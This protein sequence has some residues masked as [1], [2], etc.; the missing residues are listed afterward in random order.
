[1]HTKYSINIKAYALY[2]MDVEE[3]RKEYDDIK[4]QLVEFLTSTSLHVVADTI[5]S[6]N[7]YAYIF[8]CFR[9][10]PYNKQNAPGRA[11]ADVRHAVEEQVI[12]EVLKDMVI[13][14]GGILR[15]HVKT[16]HGP[17][18]ETPIRQGNLL[19]C[20]VNHNTKYEFKIINMVDA[21]AGLDLTVQ[22]GHKTDRKPDIVNRKMEIA[23]DDAQEV[24]DVRLDPED[25][26][27]YTFTKDGGAVL[28]VL[29]T[30]PDV[31]FPFPLWCDIPHAITEDRPRDAP[32]PDVDAKLNNIQ[33]QFEKENGNGSSSFFEVLFDDTM[34]CR[35]MLRSFLEYENV[36]VHSGAGN[37]FEVSG[38]PVAVTALYVVSPETVRVVLDTQ[39]ALEV[40]EYK[41]TRVGKIRQSAANEPTPHTITLT[42][43]SNGTTK[44][45]TF[46]VKLHRSMF[47][48][49]RS[50]EDME[51]DGFGG[52]ARHAEMRGLLTRLCDLY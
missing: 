45:E 46:D 25:V 22:R 20:R 4:S 7:L 3:M 34:K 35:C 18:F 39:T 49:K 50:A 41:A 12:R 14:P 6:R 17:L 47:N 42:R 24:D 52:A 26:H 1:M 51:V 32:R 19:W 9:I 37:V 36:H 21:I 27:L 15:V 31:D 23:D 13:V 38:V 48:L 43:V 44:S 8:C 40:P 5:L 16:F 28:R 29:F 2:S 11:T 33:T 30:A 10:N